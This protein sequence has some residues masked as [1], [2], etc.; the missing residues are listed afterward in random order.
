MRHTTITS[1]VNIDTASARDKHQQAHTLLDSSPSADHHRNRPPYACIQHTHASTHVTST[2]EID[3]SALSPT[4][5]HELD[6]FYDT[7][8]PPCMLLAQ[9]GNSINIYQ[10]NIHTFHFLDD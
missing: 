1:R 3:T 7:P 5:R 6:R 8:A 4:N 9:A 2:S 10:F